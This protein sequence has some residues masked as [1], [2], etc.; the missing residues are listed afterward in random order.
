MG[1]IKEI[2]ESFTSFARNHLLLLLYLILFVII[3][4][5]QLWTMD[6]LQLQRYLYMG[7]SARY[8]LSLALFR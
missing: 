6:I 8:L 4:L 3:S 2:K 5:A 1:I 7:F